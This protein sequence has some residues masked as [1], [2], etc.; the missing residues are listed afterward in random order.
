VA[1][2]KAEKITAAEAQA[3]AEEQALGQPVPAM[4]G[5]EREHLRTAFGAIKSGPR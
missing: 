4:R 3:K 5:D 1:D 2:F